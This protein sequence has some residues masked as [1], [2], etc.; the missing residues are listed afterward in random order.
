MTKEELIKKVEEINEQITISQN[1]ITSLRE[2]GLKIFGK[3]ELLS[4]QSNDNRNPISNNSSAVADSN[5][6]K[7]GGKDIRK[8]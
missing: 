2:E 3:L 5:N 8:T 1:R 6:E 7:K 4:E